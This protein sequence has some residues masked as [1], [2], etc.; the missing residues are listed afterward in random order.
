MTTPNEP[1]RPTGYQTGTAPYDPTESQAFGD[2]SAQPDGT[3]SLAGMGAPA[4]TGSLA[5]TGSP[6]GTGSRSG[7][8]G[9]LADAGRETA[10]S[11]QNE[12]KKV[13]ST[14]GDQASE[15]KAETGAQARRLLDESVT[16]ARTQADS[17]MT[18][19]GGRLRELADEVQQM[20]AGSDQSGP[21][22]QFAGDL[23][24]RGGRAADWLEQHGPD[25]A[26]AAVRRYAR[27]NPVSFLAAA[28]GAGLV[29]G[30]FARALQAGSP[31]ED[32][33]A[34]LRGRSAYGEPGYLQQGPVRAQTEPYDRLVEPTT[35]PA[36]A[37]GLTGESGSLGTGSMGTGSMG[38]GSMGTGSM[39]TGPMDPGS[40]GD[41]R[42]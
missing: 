30:R 25:E 24:E 27:R 22:T 8:S 33:N 42:R 13:M 23:A 21:A 41:T 6:A 7:D 19:L 5:G 14:V 31:A 20:A 1:T 28:A 38:T 40:I 37:S 3:G 11:A 15:V 26:L 9:S 34:Q 29:V 36:S 16:E 32:S 39:G 12:A 4:G 10:D 35:G 17:Q 18:R 2:P